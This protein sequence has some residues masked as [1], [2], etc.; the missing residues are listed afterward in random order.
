[1]AIAILG[2]TQ[3]GN[4]QFSQVVRQAGPSAVQVGN[5][6]TVMTLTT[7]TGTYQVGETLTGGTSAATAKITQVLS[8]NGTATVVLFLNTITGVFTNENVT[9]GTSGA[10]GTL[11]T[12]NIGI[13]EHAANSNQ[14]IYSDRVL[15]FKGS[16]YCSINN[17]ILKFDGANNWSVVYTFGNQ[18]ASTETNCHTGLYVFYVNNNPLMGILWGG[19]GLNNIYRATSSD[20]ATWAQATLATGF[21][22]N[23]SPG[24]ARAVVWNN[25]LYFAAS[26]NNSAGTAHNSWD[27]A[28][29][30]FLQVNVSSSSGGVG[31]IANANAKDFFVFQNSLLQLTTD[32]GNGHAS[33]WNFTAGNWVKVLDFTDTGSLTGGGNTPAN[34]AF[35]LFDP[36]DGNLYCLYNAFTNPSVG[37]VLK[38]VTYSGG[39]YTDAGQFQGTVLAGTGINLYPGGPDVESG[40]WYVAVDDVTVPGTPQAYLYFCSSDTAGTAINVYQWNGTASAVT[41]IGSGGNIANALPMTSR[42]G[43]GERIWGSGQPDII[44]TNI[45]AVPGGEQITYQGFGGGTKSVQFWFSTVGQAPKSQSTLNTPTGGGTLNVNGK[46]VDNVPMNGSNQTIIWA[47]A[48]DGAPNLTRVEQQPVAF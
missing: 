12:A 1:M 31:Q 17:Y 7:S 28:T 40:R 41:I 19:T 15:S 48:T 16:L 10:H 38:K 3:R 35:T 2:V 5:N 30:Q 24:V 21:G 11:S 13:L 20:G 18:N 42:A 9:G 36:G 26:F 34:S 37:W 22:M 8:G 39:V 33:L 32:S 43:G 29:D 27:P 45:A 4:T 6:F 44:I 47:A 25:V 23:G 46:Q 14:N